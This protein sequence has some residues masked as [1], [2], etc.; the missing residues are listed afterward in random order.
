MTTRQAK[1]EQRARRTAKRS[2]AQLKGLCT[3]CRRNRP[4]EGYAR[5]EECRDRSRSRSGATGEERR[6]ML[7]E[8]EG[9]CKLCRRPCVRPVVDHCHT[10]GHIRGVICLTC[11]AALGLFHE[12]PELLERAAQYLRENDGVVPHEELALCV[13]EGGSQCKPSTSIEAKKPEKGYV[14][15]IASALYAVSG[16]LYAPY[17]RSGTTIVLRSTTR[18]NACLVFERGRRPDPARW[19]TL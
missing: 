17:R 11:N 12:S 2:A 13:D 3:V 6:R 1:L 8:Q 4:T 16:E 9:L 18:P 14:M 7:E 15:R 19:V 10:H 5:C